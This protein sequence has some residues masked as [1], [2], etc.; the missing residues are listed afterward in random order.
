[1]K[2]GSMEALIGAS[3]NMKLASTPMRV[4][5]DA[6]HRGDTE[7]MER[8]MG[9]VTDFEKK[10]HECSNKAQKELAKELKEERKE[11]ELNREQA[12][13]KRKEEEKEYREK[14]QESNRADI[15]KEDSVEISE[16]GKAELKNNARI[17][18]PTEVVENTDVKVYTSEGKTVSTEAVASSLLTVLVIL[19]GMILAELL[20][21]DYG[22]MGIAIIVTFYL[23]RGK[24]IMPFVSLAVIYIGHLLNDICYMIVVY[25]KD[26]YR[27]R[28]DGMSVS[29]K[30]VFSEIPVSLKYDAVWRLVNT[31]PGAVAA[32][33]L[34]CL[35]NGLKG[36]QLP[37]AFYYLFYP[38]HLLLLYFAVKVLVPLL[39]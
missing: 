10:A 36:R 24:R 30:Q 39:G 21:T 38:V 34:I 1:M 16:E 4:Y 26:M 32:I 14:L 28:Q 6:E 7:T 18:E 15:Q 3:Q 9:Y 2:A 20:R 13:Q 25:L 31:M 8:A 17:T 29:V 5:K 11:Q 27:M 35:Y 12:I 23:L 33:L 19:L 37:K 22:L